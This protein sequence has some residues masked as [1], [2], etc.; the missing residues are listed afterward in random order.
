[1]ISSVIACNSRW[2]VINIVIFSEIP[3]WYA[4]VSNMVDHQ[5]V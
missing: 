1:M 4:P 5:I 2:K 3:N